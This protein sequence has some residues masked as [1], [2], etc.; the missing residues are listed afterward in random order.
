MAKGRKYT[1]EAL[2]AAIEDYFDSITRLVTVTEMIDTGEKDAYGHAI[3]VPRTVLNRKGQEVQELRYILPP[4]IGGLCKHLGISPTTWSDYAGRKRYGEI[5][6]RA[7]GEV[8]AYLQAE[9]LQRPDK[10][11]GGILFNIENN[12]PEFAPRKQMD[13]RE[14]ELRILKAEKELDMIGQESSAVSVELVGEADSYGV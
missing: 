13:Y 7:R 1:P 11:L 2:E 8:Y 4:T 10:A 3:K 6:K 9:T 14:Q 5:V 12:F